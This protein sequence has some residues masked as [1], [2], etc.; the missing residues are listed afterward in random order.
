MGSKSEILVF[1]MTL[2]VS[3][4]IILYNNYLSASYRH[5]LL[6]KNH[7]A[8]SPNIVCT[9][10]Y[11]N[12]HIIY[13]DVRPGRTGS[14]VLQL[15][16]LLAMAQIHCYTPVVKPQN[17]HLTIVEMYFDVDDIQR[18]DLNITGF[19]EITRKQYVGR[20]GTFLNGDYNWTVNCTCYGYR[21]TNDQIKY[22][23]STVRLKEDLVK[24]ARTFVSDNIGHRP[25][26]AVHVRRTDKALIYNVSWYEEYI[27][28]AIAVLET[29][30][31]NITF[32]FVS[33]D[34]DW[35]RK[36]FSGD[37]VY[38]SPFV[39]AGADLALMSLCKYSV[40]TVGSY[41]YSGAWF[42]QHDTVIY[43]RKYALMQYKH[44]LFFSPNWIELE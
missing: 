17:R 42:G 16:S 4:S 30:V 31:T 18:V 1:L 25:L 39:S 44:L 2:V 34:K 28:K 7:S 37:N 8:L 21:F 6:T 27:K 15:M 41:G 20:L 29:L 9:K 33:D 36:H 43:N 22:L 23:R 14:S 40:L 24:E 26:A 19:R 10:Q 13:L 11:K 5:A 32:V 35:C 3:L 12:S 38:F